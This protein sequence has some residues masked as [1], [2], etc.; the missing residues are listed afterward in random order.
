MMKNK[1]RLTTLFLLLVLILGVAALITKGIY[2]KYET[3]FHGNEIPSAPGI[4]V[5]PV[6]TAP[7]SNTTEE[8]Y[9]KYENDVYGF[10]IMYPTSMKRVDPQTAGDLDGL[11]PKNIFTSEIPREVFEGTNLRRVSIIAGAKKTDEQTCTYKI[12]GE[13]INAR[14]ESNEPRFRTIKDIRW[15]IVK[16]SGAAAGSMYSTTRYSTYR[17]GTCYELIA[18]VQSGN[19]PQFDEKNMYLTQ[20]EEIVSFF[21]LI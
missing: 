5:E 20:F 16:V 10:S 17:N 7:F 21:T 4:P 6:D 18:N 13:D 2:Y 3:E 9:S 8:G 19:P 1:R 15:A 14:D 12:H 11:D